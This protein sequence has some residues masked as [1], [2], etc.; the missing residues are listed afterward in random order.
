MDSM[1][2]CPPELF[3]ESYPD[4]IREQAERLRALMRQV[5]P[6][7]IERVRLGWRLIGYDLL[8]GRRRTYFAWVAPE[9]IHVHIG[10]QVGTLM[11]DPDRLLRGAR[12]HLRKVRYLTFKA[13][14]PIPED[15]VL[16]F[17]AEAARVAA[18]S[19]EERLMLAVDR[20]WGPD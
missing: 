8:V 19:R 1:D 7:A 10:F 4:G 9:P 11:R 15:T 20:D 5:V 6:D 3:L 12:L 18:L 16:E 14:E 2:D 17:I 13:G